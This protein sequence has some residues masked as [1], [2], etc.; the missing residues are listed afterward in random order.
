MSSV[1]GEKLRVS[2]FGQSHSEAIG[3]VLDGFPHG[4]RIDFDQLQAF[5]LRRAARG[6]LS[7]ARREPDKPEFLS[8]FKNGVTCGAPISAII[9]NTNVRS[10]DYRGLSNTPRP[11]HADFAVSR[12]YGYNADYSGGGHLSGRL[13]AAFCIAGGICIQ[14]LESMGV[15]VGAH[16]YSI[17]GIKDRP[18]DLACIDEETLK[19]VTGKSFPVIDE[20]A[21]ERMKKRILEAKEEQDSVGGIIE[22][23]AV[24]L[25]AG[26]GS[27]HFGGLEN[28]ISSAVFG[29]PAVKGIEFGN[30]FACSELTGSQN[31]D[32]FYVA[33]D[34][35]IKTGTNNSG[36]VNGGITNGMPVVG[37]IAVRPT[38]SISR[39]QDSVDLENRKSIQLS[40][41]G[42]HDPCI[43][44]RAVPC[45][46]A[47]VAIAVTDS[48]L[49]DK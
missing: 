14:Y 49:I 1:Y 6:N 40:T 23:A 5:L 41:Q 7:T 29:V 30:G 8:G 28:R 44:H 21:G 46:E 48:I 47:A 39:E 31:N 10:E 35:G 4:I 36:G 37:R 26:I 3:V 24:G 45:I 13:T 27:P 32:A 19:A 42:R 34:G 22:F 17:A 25:P 15:S 20:N 18:F 38:P 11:S 43:M 33:K 12:K 9:R 16:I 2:L